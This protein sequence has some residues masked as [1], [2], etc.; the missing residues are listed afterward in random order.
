M[1]DRPP[2]KD[3]VVLVHSKDFWSLRDAE[4]IHFYLTGLLVKIKDLHLTAK[5]VGRCGTQQS[6]LTSTET[7][8]PA[9]LCE[10]THGYLAGLLVWAVGWHVEAVHCVGVVLG[11]GRGDEV[12]MA[13]L[14]ISLKNG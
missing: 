14:T 12:P 10:T 5:P 7:A 3:T 4:T 11:L 6:L 2:R 1:P 13:S 8:K 9:S